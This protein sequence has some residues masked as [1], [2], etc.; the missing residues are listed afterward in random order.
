MSTKASRNEA[1]KLRA[2]TLNTI[3]LAVL[4]L[5]ALTPVLTDTPA[6]DNLAGIAGNCVLFYILHLLAGFQL[7]DLED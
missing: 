1:L 4:G 6:Q 7:R 2:T 3:G 5:G